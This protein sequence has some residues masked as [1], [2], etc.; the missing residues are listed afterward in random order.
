MKR[1]FD[2]VF[3]LLVLIVL[4]P[5]FIIIS[6]LIII[7]DG[8]PVFYFQERIGKNF[9]PFRL[10]KFRTMY[11]DADKKGLLT[12]SSKDSRITKVGYYLRK[13]KLD[14]LPQFINVLKGDMSVVGP[15]PEVRK[16][17]ELYNDDQKKVLS[18]KPGIT[19]EASLKY[20]DES[21]ILAKSDDP[22]KTY[23]EQIM[24]EKLSINLHY[25]KHQNFIYD[26]KIIF[27]TFTKSLFRQ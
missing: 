20:I 1:L 3:S 5:V 23:I 16:Y 10:I 6:L 19:D 25:I 18:V 13:Y 7:D 14:E 12:T 15:R 8:F 22:E 9:K 27:Q 24:P 17:V 2:I 26:L 4:L 21:D 11:K